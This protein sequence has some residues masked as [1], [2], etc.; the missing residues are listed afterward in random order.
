[1][2]KD[3]VGISAKVLSSTLKLLEENKLIHREELLTRPIMVRYS[4]AP[5][6]SK[7]QELLQAMVQ[8]GRAHRLQI[9]Q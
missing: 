9:M 4:I 6:G 3:L 8:W 7:I 1:M 5:Y 2:E